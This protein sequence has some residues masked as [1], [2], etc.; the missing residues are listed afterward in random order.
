MIREAMDHP[1]DFDQALIAAYT[2]QA[3]NLVPWSCQV[4]LTSAD[5]AAAVR[6]DGKD[7]HRPP[8]SAMHQEGNAPMS[9]RTSAASVASLL[10]R[11]RA[12]VS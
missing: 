2:S 7:K 6:Y 9:V 12:A 8:T 3:A 4:Y 1:A 5:P 11:T 10:I